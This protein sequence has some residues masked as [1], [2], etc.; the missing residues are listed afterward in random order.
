[1]RI[2]AGYAWCL[3]ESG[4][5]DEAL[6]FLEAAA[7]AYPDDVDVAKVLAHTYFEAGQPLAAAEIFHR[8]SLR[9]PALISEA[10]ELYR[11][12]GLLFRALSLNGEIVDQEKKLKQRLAI[13]LG[14]ERFEEITAMEAAMFR[15]GLLEDEDL[16]YAM[17]YAWFKVGNY[18]KAEEHIARLTR[19]DLFRKG[20][21]LREIMEECRDAAWRCS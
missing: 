11:R 9:D 6:R 13:F 7:L 3:A 10:A 17:G 14:L 20:V 8:A 5:R 19:S 15:V 21:E 4:Q 16:R 18:E 12:A 2:K 1:M